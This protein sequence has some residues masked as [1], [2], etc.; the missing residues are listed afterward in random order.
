ML[1]S[2]AASGVIQDSNV[3]TGILL[4][5]GLGATGRGELAAVL[6]WPGMLAALFSLGVT[7]A[8]TY[9]AARNKEQT[10]T[11]LW[12]VVWLGLAQ[13][14][15]AVLLGVAI[16][17]F[18]LSDFDPSTVE[19]AYLYLPYI[20]V[21]L[22]ALFL[23]GVLNG[24]ARH[25]AFQLLRVAVIVVAALLLIALTAFDH[26]EVRAAALA[27]LV[28]NIL[29][30]FGAVYALRDQWQRPSRPSRRLLS[31]VLAFGLKSHTTSVSTFFNQRL[32]QLVISLLLAPAQLGIYVVAVTLTAITSLVGYSIAL[33]ALPATARAPAVRRAL[34]ARTFVGA[35]T[36]TSILVTVPIL[37]FTPQIVELFFGPGFAEAATVARI[38][39]V[40]AVAFSTSRVL[41]A[42]L[43][44][45]GRPL[46]AGIAEGAALA[47]TLIGLLILLPALELIGAGL[48]SFIAYTA[49]VIFMVRRTT[50]ALNLTSSELLIADRTTL[51][52]LMAEVRTQTG[53]G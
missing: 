13:G 10:P 38:L 22:L 36:A 43:Q 18:V 51:A 26:L 41:E 50:Q 42:V 40:G 20:P 44:A 4:A 17:P 31:E 12:T 24:L 46:D 48:A 28:A 34:E 8:A 32:D 16:L 47:F 49:S 35:A 33:V 39:L 53:P 45:I 52:R 11:L 19:S 9:F 29:T 37:I 5:R 21:S 7:P 2:F 25:R 30:L 1:F 14:V 6:L 23:M 27:Y 3:I 15:L